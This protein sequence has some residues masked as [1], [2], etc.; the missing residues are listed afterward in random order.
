MTQSE[1]IAADVARIIRE[2]VAKA[3][4]QQSRPSTPAARLTLP[5]PAG[6]AYSRGVIG[7]II[8]DHDRGTT[9]YD[10]FDDGDVVRA[11]GPYHVAARIE[12]IAEAR[13]AGWKVRT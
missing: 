12:A 13:R 3:A 9:L 11:N 5:D 10:L 8:V 6:D 1:K 2:R 4:T 7:Q